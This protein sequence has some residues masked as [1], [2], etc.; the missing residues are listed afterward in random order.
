ML[1]QEMRFLAAITAFSS[2]LSRRSSCST[3]PR[4]VS[5]Y[6]HTRV[7]AHRALSSC[8][9]SSLLWLLPL[10]LLTA[11]SALPCLPCA[12]AAVAQGFGYVSWDGHEWQRTVLLGITYGTNAHH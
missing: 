1:R 9:H 10:L 7:H 12:T 3:A 11:F 8:Y 5:I 2:T 4:Y 6:I